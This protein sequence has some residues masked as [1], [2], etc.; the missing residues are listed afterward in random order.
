MQSKAFQN[1]AILSRIRRH[2][3]GNLTIELWLLGIGIALG[4]SLFANRVANKMGVPV[5]ILFLVAGMLAGSDGPGG[6]WFSNA[7]LTEH[8]GVVALAFILFA[9]GMDLNWKEA[10]P[11]SVKAV[12]LATVGVIVTG[13]VVGFAAVRWLGFSRPEGFL[14]GAIIASTDASVVFTALRKGGFRLK[15]DLRS[16]LEMES[17]ANDPTAI[18]LTIA[19]VSLLSGEFQGWGPAVVSFVWQMA[20][21]AFGGWAGGRIGGF[22]MRR[23]RLDFE[24]MYQWVS[25]TVVLLTFGVVALMGGNGFLAVYVAGV[26]FGNGNFRQQQDLQ[27]FHDGVSWLMQVVLFIVLGLLVFPRQLPPVIWAGCVIAGTLMFIA[28]P[29][30]VFATLTPFRVPF[31]EQVFV[32]WCGLRGAVPIVLATYPLLADITRA[33]EIFHMVFFVVIISALFQGTTI[34]ALAKRF[35]LMDS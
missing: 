11:H 18:F 31:K 4:L 34:L 19:L 20:M 24:G 23:L 13:L 14:L 25:I 12:L 5:L 9:G 7:H 22:A 3:E 33:H 30:A 28:R 27:R 8:I 2:D 35:G 21:G 29:L 6:V 15:S 1:C 32:A 17:G 26:A 10:R 16:M